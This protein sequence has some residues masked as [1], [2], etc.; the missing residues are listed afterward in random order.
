MDLYVDQDYMMELLD[1]ITETVIARNKALRRCDGQPEKSK[2]FGFA[3]DSIALLSLDTYT[4]LILPFHKKM[5]R[6]LCTGE[7]PG[8][9]HLSRGCFPVLPH[10][11]AGTERRHIRYGL[12][13]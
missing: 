4:E 2:S 12:P 8:W 3:D 1:Y 9:I 5:M 6:E 10:T 7:E 13:H 11:G